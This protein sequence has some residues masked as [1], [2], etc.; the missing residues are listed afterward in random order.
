MI[1][2]EDD[3]DFGINKQTDNPMELSTSWDT[4]SCSATQEFPI[5]LW[6]PKVHYRAKTLPLVSTLNQMIPAHTSHPFEYNP[7]TYV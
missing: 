5:I 1:W 3:N 7:P 2:S 6:N 4:S